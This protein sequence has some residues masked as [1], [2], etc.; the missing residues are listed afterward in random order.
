VRERVCVCVWV[1]VRER[2]GER[3]YH[4]RCKSQISCVWRERE[5]ERERVC[6]RERLCIGVCVREKEEERV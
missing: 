6:V 1:C 2:G 3:V 5:T 4:W